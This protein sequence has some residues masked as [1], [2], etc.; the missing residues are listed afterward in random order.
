[1]LFNRYP[2]SFV[3]RHFFSPSLT[4]THFYF[5]PGKRSEDRK[6]VVHPLLYKYASSA[7][8]CSLIPSVRLSLLLSLLPLI[9]RQE[10]LSHTMR[11]ECE[12]TTKTLPTGLNHDDDEDSLIPDSHTHTH[13]PVCALV[14]IIILPRKESV[15]VLEDLCLV[16]GHTTAFAHSV[17]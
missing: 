14:A 8:L 1:M 15:L 16:A 9:R 7:L 4:L 11:C 13:D 17:S 3:V 5:S 10:F 2:L 12:R 6:K